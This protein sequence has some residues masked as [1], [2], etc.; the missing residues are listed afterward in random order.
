MKLSHTLLPLAVTIGLGAAA[1]GQ[2]T[3]EPGTPPPAPG[4][5]E[6]HG[7]PPSVNPGPPEGGDPGPPE[8]VK[9]EFIPPGFSNRVTP[10]VFTSEEPTAGALQVQDSGTAAAA[11]PVLLRRPLE[12][13]P[14]T[15]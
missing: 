8:S 7:P 12:P 5:P 1:Q 11:G 4:Q 14:A 9:P 10:T 13:A 3:N 6:G 2:G 15:P